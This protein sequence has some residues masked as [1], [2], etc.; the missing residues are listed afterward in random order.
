M[1]RFLAINRFV[2]LSCHPRHLAGASL[3]PPSNLTHFTLPPGHPRH[4]A[5]ASLKLD[6]DIFERD[7]REVIPGI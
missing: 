2:N 7:K 1:K 6:Y 4:L 3:K 5:G